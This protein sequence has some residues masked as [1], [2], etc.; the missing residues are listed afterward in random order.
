MSANLHL[1]PRKKIERG[2]ALFP[3]AR[4]GS[5]RDDIAGLQFGEAAD[6]GD[7]RLHWEQHERGVR[8]L[9]HLP[10]DEGVQAV[11]AP[12]PESLGPDQRWANAT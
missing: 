12:V 1:V 5:R 6:V 10:V 8:F 7:Q 3:D 9:H 11:A 4:A 2:H